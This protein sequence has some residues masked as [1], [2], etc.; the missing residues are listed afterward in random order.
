[1][2]LTPIRTSTFWWVSQVGML[3]ATAVFLYAGSTVPSLE[4]LA[5]RVIQSVFTPAQ[6]TRIVMALT[7]LGIFP[8]AVR[9]SMKLVARLRK[10]SIAVVDRGSSGTGESGDGP[11]EHSIP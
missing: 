1:M 2:G 7:L 9:W 10:R 3:P 5:E 11:P 4:T 6:I 8:L